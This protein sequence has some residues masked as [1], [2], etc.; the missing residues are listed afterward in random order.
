LKAL[1]EKIPILRNQVKQEDENDEKVRRWAD[2]IQKYINVQHLD[3]FMARKL[4]ESISV[5]AYYKVNGINFVNHLIIS[6]AD[7]QNC[8][9]LRQTKHANV[10]MPKLWLPYSM[11]SRSRLGSPKFSIVDEETKR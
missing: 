10:L 2:T 4:I 5:S 7:T 3:R 8:D 6:V 9:S 11:S 1:E